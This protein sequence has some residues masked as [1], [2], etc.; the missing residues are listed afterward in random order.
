MR[1][2]LDALRQRG[3][4]LEGTTLYAPGRTMWLETTVAWPKSAERFLAD[5]KN[6]RQRVIATRESVTPDE[7]D[8]ALADVESAIKAAEAVV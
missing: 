3:W 7:F 4:E 8:V 5:M 6:R 1:D 2:L